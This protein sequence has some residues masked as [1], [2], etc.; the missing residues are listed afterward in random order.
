MIPMHMI[1]VSKSLL[2]W[3]QDAA[4]RPV[5]V[6]IILVLILTAPRIAP[7]EE[8]QW[9]TDYQAARKEA[10]ASNRPMIL[11]FQ[12]ANCLWCRKL[13]GTTFQ[14]G[15]IIELLNKRFVPLKVD[16]E[17]NMALVGALRVSS[18]PTLVLASPDGK[19]LATLEGYVDA[20]KLH[21]HL[22]RTLNGVDNPPWMT[23]DYEEA[24]KAIATSDY[25]RAI[26]LLRAICED[27]KK[28]T[29][30]TRARQVL[31]DL[32]QQG[33]DCLQRA[34]ALNDKGQVAE[35]A[36]ALS[37]LVRLYAGTQS[38]AEGGRL[39]TSLS[40]GSEIRVRIRT[41]RA[42]EL[43]AQAKEDYRTEQYLWCL[44]RCEVLASTYSDLPEAAEAAQLSQE[45]K[46][47]PQWLQKACE[48]MTARLCNFY[49]LM[50]ETWVRKG[51]PQQAA[52]YLKRVIRSFP[53]TSQAETAQARLAALNGR[54]TLQATFSKDT[55]EKR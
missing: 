35:A 29:I 11:D 25:A 55:E 40:T 26:A 38:A 41:Q 8:V 18:Y 23:R 30:Q 20:H 45:I 17:Q 49:L 31:A 28:R 33:A 54:Q 37:E 3:L 42:R 52:D 5:G 1:P 47:N 7:A 22:Q 10:R 2:C 53:G 34:Q 14:E 44:E 12:T 32:E 6:L 15:A 13:D 46:N 48:T 9:R 36:A 21:D 50:A 43:L 39:L 51:Q 27:G 4:R 19:I 24:S 16:A